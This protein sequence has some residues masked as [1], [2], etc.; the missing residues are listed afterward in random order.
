MWWNCFNCPEFT[1][2]S[3]VNL[4]V[5]W[6]PLPHFSWSSTLLQTIFHNV[7]PLSSLTWNTCISKTTQ[8]WT[9]KTSSS[10]CQRQ[11]CMCI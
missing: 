1:F 7:K 8:A 9:P 6:R 4:Y 3:H 11:S 10:K 2:G 5:I